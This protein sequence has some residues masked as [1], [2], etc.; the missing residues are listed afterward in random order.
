[1][2]PGAPPTRRPR[3]PAVA[4][5][6]VRLARWRRGRRLAWLALFVL[7]ASVLVGYAGVFGY[8][9]DDWARFD[10]RRFRVVHVVAGD[11]LVVRPADGPSDAPK[12]TVRLAGVA[13]PAA[14]EHWAAESRLG[15]AARAEGKD[16]TFRL[17]ATQTRAAD[18]TLLAHAYAADADHLNLSLVRDGHAYADR[19]QPHA[20]QQQF[21]AAET[22]ARLKRRGLWQ[23]VAEPQMPPWRREWLAAQ[24][25]RRQERVGPRTRPG[26]G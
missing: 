19:R 4:R 18:G 16:V 10:R 6:S 12:V 9:G 7:A 2:S 26:G 24:R 1:M 13:A 3:G 23:A 21:E 11:T 15:L 20:W 14:G 17:E 22:D 25:Q 8:G 5:A